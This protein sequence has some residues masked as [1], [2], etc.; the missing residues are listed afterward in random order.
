MPGPAP[1]GTLVDALDLPRLSGWYRAVLGLQ[2]LRADADHQV[3]EG[4]GAQLILHA[5]PPVHAEGVVI[6]CPPEPREDQTIKPWFTVPS[7]DEA[8]RAAVAHGGLVVGPAY[9]VV[10]HRLR[11]AVDPEGNI[12]QLR[13]PVPSTPWPETPPC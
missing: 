5:I 4:G 6:A 1:H 3:L 12:V 10:G 11:N 13:A 9:T 7:L 2:V 8:E